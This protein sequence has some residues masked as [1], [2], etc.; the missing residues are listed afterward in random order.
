MPGVVK[1]KPECRHCGAVLEHSFSRCPRCGKRSLLN[2]FL[3]GWGQ[4]Y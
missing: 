4:R 1:P 3:R 2:L